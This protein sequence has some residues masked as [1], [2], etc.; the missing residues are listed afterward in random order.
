L[1]AGMLLA[2][3]RGVIATM[4]TIGDTDAPRIADG[5][6]SHILKAGKPDYT[7]AAFALHQAVQRLRL[8]GASFLSWV[9]YIH[10]GF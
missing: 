6:Y 8:Q 4:W 10:I 3:Y 9:P 7:Q 1:A 2:G 5:V